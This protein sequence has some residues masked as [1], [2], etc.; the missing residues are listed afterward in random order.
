MLPQGGQRAGGDDTFYQEDWRGTEDPTAPVTGPT[1]W[2]GTAYFGDELI[3]T[4]LGSALFNTETPMPTVFDTS[5]SD[6]S[7]EMENVTVFYADD[8]AMLALDPNL[9]DPFVGNLSEWG[10]LREQPLMVKGDMIIDGRKMGEINQRYLRK[11]AVQAG[12]TT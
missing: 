11:E 6:F 10:G 3:T 12:E 7:G 4:A 1:G 5:D 8:A 2:T 9:S